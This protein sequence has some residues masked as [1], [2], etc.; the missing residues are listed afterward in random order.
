[1]EHLTEHQLSQL[2]INYLKHAQQ[3]RQTH[4]RL[5]PAEFTE[6]Y[7]GI[8]NKLRQFTETSYFSSFI[9]ACADLE[10]LITSAESACNRG[11]MGG[12]KLQ[13]YYLLQ[14][15]ILMLLASRIS[16]QQ[17]ALLKWALEFLCGAIESGCK[18]Q[19]IFKIA[20]EVHIAQLKKY[21]DYFSFWNR[22][23]HNYDEAAAPYTS[24]ASRKFIFYNK[25]LEKRYLQ[26][27][28]PLN[29]QLFLW[30]KQLLTEYLRCGKPAEIDYSALLQGHVSMPAC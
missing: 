1:M 27:I 2:I 8:K 25:Q 16:P 15:H 17:P 9:E 20:L 3:P 11:F 28:G 29:Q 13:E 19:G 23:L 10:D 12:H 4:N 6:W 21:N 30:S 18:N 22:F 5:H 26:E 24:S 7:A 14:S